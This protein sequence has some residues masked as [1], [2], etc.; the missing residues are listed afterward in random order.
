MHLCLGRP[1]FSGQENDRYV[2]NVYSEILGGGMS[3]IL[4]QNLREKLGLCYSIFSAHSPYQKVGAFNIYAGIDPQNVQAATRAI[5]QELEKLAA[6]DIADDLL[7][8][9]K[10]SMV[11]TLVFARESV[12]T[13]M[14]QAGRKYLN[15]G[16]RVAIEETI[17]HIQKVSKKDIRRIAEEFADINKYSIA[18]VADQK[19]TRKAVL[20]A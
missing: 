3:S 5:R 13:R 12:Q 2:L 15:T 19:L 10:V 11:S 17:S 14:F 8:R 20:G 6:K 18:V 16:K 1:G 4:F 7:E 9:A